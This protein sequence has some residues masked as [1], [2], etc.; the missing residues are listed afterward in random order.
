MKR[1][2]KDELKQLSVAELAK[3]VAELTKAIRANALERVTKEV[4]NTR[5]GRQLRKQ[6]AIV[7][8]ILRMKTI[9]EESRNL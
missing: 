6:R 4:K 1:K 3:R 9:A 5:I 8:S 7:W 2:D